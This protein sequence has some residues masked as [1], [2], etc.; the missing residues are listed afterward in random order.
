MNLRV[1]KLVRAADFSQS[2]TW[3]NGTS[4]TTT[5]TIPTAPTGCIAR[6]YFP[7]YRNSL[8]TAGQNNGIM[9]SFAAFNGSNSS[10]AQVP[11]AGTGY[12]TTRGICYNEN[13]TNS[14]Q[15]YSLVTTNLASNAVNTFYLARIASL[16]RMG[17]MM[18]APNTVSGSWLMACVGQMGIVMLPE[19]RPV[20]ITE[21]TG[22]SGTL[23][24]TFALYE[25]Y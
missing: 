21:S 3:S 8:A 22:D 19:E 10:Y 1:R 25:I 24:T 5:I 7:L 20:V 12:L 15:A 6:F 13:F 4:N 9:L 17:L 14:Q 23:T 11:P 16:D 2:L 18:A